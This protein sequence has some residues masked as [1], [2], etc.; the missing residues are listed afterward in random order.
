MALST[1]GD[2]LIVHVAVDNSISHDTKHILSSTLLGCL[3]SEKAHTFHFSKVVSFYE[4][5]AGN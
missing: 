3:L 5:E 2:M 1:G 4:T